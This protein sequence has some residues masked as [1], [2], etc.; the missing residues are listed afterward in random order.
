MKNQAKMWERKLWQ[1]GNHGLRLLSKR[2][3]GMT[4]KLNCPIVAGT[5]QQRL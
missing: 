1:G 5:L 3:Q 4:K 2:E